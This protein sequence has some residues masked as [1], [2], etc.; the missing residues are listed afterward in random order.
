MHH[1]LPYK[2]AYSGGSFAMEC[3][4]G[5]MS[6]QAYASVIFALVAFRSPSEFPSCLETNLPDSLLRSRLLEMLHD[7]LEEEIHKTTNINKFYTLQ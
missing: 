6:M 2:L 7:F 5:L 4:N 3:L 1:F